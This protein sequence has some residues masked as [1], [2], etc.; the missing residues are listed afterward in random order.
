MTKRADNCILI[1][2]FHDS[3]LGSHIAERTQLPTGFIEITNFADMETYVRIDSDVKNKIVV[4]IARLDH[5]NDRFLPLMFVL[6]TLHDMG[7][8]KIILVAPYIPYLRQDKKFKSGEA[9]TSKQFAQFFDGRIDKL[10]TIDPHLHR[11]HQLNELYHAECTVLH[12]AHL[13][14]NWINDNL[15]ESVIIGPDK[16]SKPWI[17][18]I[19]KETDSPFY[20]MKKVRKDDDTVSVTI[21]EI[22]E[23]KR[24]PVFIDDIISKGIALC[25]GMHELASRGFKDPVCIGI[26][27]IFDKELYNK[28]TKAGAQQIVTSNSVPNFTNKIDVTDLIISG[29]VELGL[30]K[31]LL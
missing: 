26:H 23:N 6:D 14:S 24:L 8:R 16:D 18:Q 7:A 4:I 13:I 19:A 3:P 25:A 20:I 11:F 17:S 10:I 27:G 12:A 15:S 30:V 5:P 28:L 29:L 9:V 22:K 1:N 2:L 21:P 31:S